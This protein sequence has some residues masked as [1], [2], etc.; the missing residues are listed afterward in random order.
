MKKVLATL[1]CL[2]MVI[3]CVGLLAACHKHTFDQTKWESDEVNHWHPATCK[4]TDEHGDEA[5]HAWG[6]DNKCEVCSR[7]K[8]VT[9]PAPSGDDHDH[10]FAKGWTSDATHHWHAATC[11][12]T[13]EVDGKAEHSFNE[14]KRCTV[15]DYQGEIEFSGSIDEATWQA[16]FAALEGMQNFTFYLTGFEGMDVTLEVMQDVLHQRT[17][18]GNS[19]ADI[20]VVYDGDVRIFYNY[21]DEYDV[22]EVDSETVTDNN[23]FEAGV[24]QLSDLFGIAEAVEVAATMYSSCHYDATLG[25]YVLD[26]QIDGVDY[27][28]EAKFIGNSVYSFKSVATAADGRSSIFFVDAIG[29]TDFEI[30]PLHQ[31]EFSTVWSS[32]NLYHWHE[33]ICHEG[34]VD[35]KVAHVWGADDKC[36]TCGYTK[37]A[38]SNDKVDKATF[39][40]ALQFKGLTNWT[41]QLTEYGEATMFCKRAGN[42][43]QALLDY[44]NYFEIAENGD[45][46]EYYETPQGAW[47]KTTNETNFAYLEMQLGSALA[48]LSPLSGL[49]EELVYKNGVYTAEACTVF[50]ESN[51]F[52]IEYM[53]ATVTF[54][55]D[56]GE[57]VSISVANMFGSNV[58]ASLTLNEIASTTVSLPN[59]TAHT[60]DYVLDRLGISE[61]SHLMRCSCGFSRD[62][63]HEY[64]ANKVCT[65]CGA[66]NHEHTLSEW[67]A[68]AKQLDYHYAVC[69]CGVMLGAGQ[70]RFEDGSTTCIECGAPKHDHQWV[71]DSDVSEYYHRVK[72][73]LCG[74]RTMSDHDWEGT[75][76]ACSVCGYKEHQ[77]QWVVVN[78]GDT[79]RHDR[80][81]SVCGMTSTENHDFQSGV[82]AQC[83]VKEH[84]HKW[85]WTGIYDMTEHQMRCSQCRDSSWLEHVFGNDGVH[86]D[87]CGEV[88]H[89]HDYQFVEDF[90]YYDEDGHSLWCEGCR[91]TSWSAHDWAA[92]GKT[93]ETCG[94]VK[95][96]HVLTVVDADSELHW[97]TCSAPNCP[98]GGE[99]SDYHDYVNADEVCSVCGVKNH[100]H[101][102]TGTLIPDPNDVDNHLDVCECGL[103]LSSANHYFG[104]YDEGEFCEQCGAT[105]HR[106]DW[107]YVPGQC[108]VMLL[109][110]YVYCADCGKDAIEWH[111]FE[112]NEEYCDVCGAPRHYHNVTHWEYLDDWNHEGWCDDCGF[113]CERHEVE[114]WTEEDEW[115]HQGQCKDC[116]ATLHSDHYLYDGEHCN[117]CD[118]TRS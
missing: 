28:Y 32:N 75:D 117:D 83:G 51:F 104:L 42:Q 60:H 116:G 79:E 84:V 40:K 19:V 107:Q 22:W 29:N 37:A 80:E 33:A 12:H 66:K 62:A 91:N 87:V 8:P 110:H 68:D 77:H 11:A 24:E 88:R 55:F 115:Q 69:E 96:E 61:Y 57:L 17:I 98:Y 67:K 36:T 49:W 38:T 21:S 103:I 93:C 95:H 46:W 54:K 78:T 106:H 74:E 111:T 3:G 56:D 71:F 86:C 44:M 109:Y 52:D 113:V 65:V 13:T 9:P 35:A 70:H 45:L 16:A 82:C 4:H 73:A 118:Y 1:L 43:V 89:D 114:T 64:D 5:E 27:H 20:Y 90:C 34:E 105:H 39:E 100:D 7:Q 2:V 10:T 18:S 102:S 112:T 108:D 23:S 25:A 81:C 85:Q 31:H 99:F 15:C 97:V 59:A 94:Y 72:C 6:A 41:L 58:V 26:E 92:D 50:L 48:G 76:G 63:R 47:V 14:F 101:E 30:V 53:N